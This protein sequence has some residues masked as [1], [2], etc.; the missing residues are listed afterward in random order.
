M[1]PAQIA[2]PVTYLDAREAVSL[3][4]SRDLV[5][6]AFAPPGGSSSASARIATAG[7]PLAGSE[8]TALDERLAEIPNPAI[9]A[10][11]SA[12]SVPDAPGVQEGAG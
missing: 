10:T 2:G 4:A 5:H 1:K 3:P 7:A 11:R 9:P 8:W 12:A 6:V